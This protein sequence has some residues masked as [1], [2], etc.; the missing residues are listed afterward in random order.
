MALHI[1]PGSKHTVAGRRNLLRY[2]SVGR[3]RAVLRI[4]HFQ[5]PGLGRVVVNS[6]KYR[7]AC[8]PQE[9]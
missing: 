4:S 9:A 3:V 2:R 7:L 8:E 6:R 5:W 1:E